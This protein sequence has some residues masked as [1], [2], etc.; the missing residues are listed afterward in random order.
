[1]NATERSLVLLCLH[2]YFLHQSDS[3]EKQEFFFVRTPV[4]S[5]YNPDDYDCWHFTHSRRKKTAIHQ[6]L[7]LIQ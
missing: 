3:W 2:G 4:G 1:M 6:A 7:K 5:P